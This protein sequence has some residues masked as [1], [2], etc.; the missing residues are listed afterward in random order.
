[1]LYGQ[2]DP[3][4]DSGPDVF[5]SFTTSRQNEGAGNVANGRHTHTHTNTDADT[6]ITQ[7]L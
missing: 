6:Y 3:P 7:M 5:E 4:C 2:W 1:M